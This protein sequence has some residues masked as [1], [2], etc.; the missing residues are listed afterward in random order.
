MPA[1]LISTL[2]LL[3]ALFSLGLFIYQ[4]CRKRSNQ[5]HEFHFARLIYYL[6]VLL[7]FIAS[8]LFAFSFN[9]MLKINKQYGNV[10]CLAQ[11]LFDAP[12]KGE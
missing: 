11:R 5:S 10:S 12:V 1:F 7:A 2:L 4:M 8:I 9:E 3:L 6:S